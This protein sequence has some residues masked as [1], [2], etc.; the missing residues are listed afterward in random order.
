M[1]WQI[2]EGTELEA[3]EKEGEWYLVVVEKPDGSRIRGYV[4]ES[5]VEVITTGSKPAAVA[6]VSKPETR[7]LKPEEVRPGREKRAGQGYLVFLGG[8]GLYLSPADLN[9]AAQGVTDYYLAE[10]GTGKKPV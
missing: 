6:A 4:H 5:L 3:E 10:L 9:R 2:V 8:G 7:R 1:L